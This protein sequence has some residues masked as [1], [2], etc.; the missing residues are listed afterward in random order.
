[1][2]MY[3]MTQSLPDRALVGDFT[4]IFIDSMYYTPTPKKIEESKVANGN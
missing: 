3:G 1:M 4:R 2:A